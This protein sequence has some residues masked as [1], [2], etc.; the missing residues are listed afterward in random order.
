[1]RFKIVLKNIILEVVKKQTP[2]HYLG[3]S[4]LVRLQALLFLR[5]GVGTTTTSTGSTS[6]GEKTALYNCVD[7]ITSIKTAKS[8]KT[9]TAKLRPV[10]H[11]KV[12][13]QLLPNMLL[14]N[15]VACA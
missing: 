13:Q 4:H 15:S 1:M 6:L 3:V 8:A 12:S 9:A 5:T 14:N 7:A 10:Q 11:K 2:S